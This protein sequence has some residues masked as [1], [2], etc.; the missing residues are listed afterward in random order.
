MCNFYSPEKVQ[1]WKFDGESVPSPGRR[2]I[3]VSASKYPISGYYTD[4]LQDLCNH[5]LYQFSFLYN[6]GF[7]HIQGNSTNLKPHALLFLNY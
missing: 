4:L 7:Q 1:T 5:Y 3:K 2:L 6:L